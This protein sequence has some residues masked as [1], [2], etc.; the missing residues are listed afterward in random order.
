MLWPDAEALDRSVRRA[1]EDQGLRI[2]DLPSGLRVR[3]TDTHRFRFNH[4]PET[5]TCDHRTVGPA[6]V[7]R[8]RLDDTCRAD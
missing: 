5:L 1:A 4:A 7:V 3:D 6:G 8:E 2:L